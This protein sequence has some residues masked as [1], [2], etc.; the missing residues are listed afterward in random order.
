MSLTL[1][2][3]DD[4][5][6]SLIRDFPHT[7]TLSGEGVFT[8]TVFKLYRA[9]LYVSGQCYDATQPFILELSYLRTLP[10]EMIVSA[11]VEELK[12]LRQP[13]PETLQTWSDSL[14]SIVPD[15]TLDDRLVGCF[16]PGQ[17]IS[18]YSASERLGEIPD[19]VFAEA[20]AAIWLDPDT[21]S[22]P[23]REAL[24]GKNLRAPSHE[25]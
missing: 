13:S 3:A 7:W 16:V 2:Q 15:V 12:R 18:F 24:L 21:R 5:P 10:C 23:L 11:S 4:L 22:A 20:F 19:P 17:G 6:A 9:R 8:W 1:S 25:A 14:N